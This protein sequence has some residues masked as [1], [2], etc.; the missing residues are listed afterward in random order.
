[1][2]E[3]SWPVQ[4][5]E[6]YPPQPYGY[7]PPT[8]QYNQQVNVAVMPAS[9]APSFGVRAVWYIFIGW[10][11]GGLVI[12]LGYLTCWIPPL[13]FWFLNRI[14]RAMTLRP[15]TKSW[16]YVQT[17][18]GVVLR[19]VKQQQVAWYWRGLYFICIGLWIGAVWLTLAYVLCL[20]VILMPIGMMM[21]NRTPGVITLEKH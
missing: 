6:T 19:E 17:A 15:I 7:P 9:S 16:E 11:L 5:P 18:A 3:P 4:Q 1:M 21:I 12:T 10:W 20:T 2:T 13:S 8:T 14:G